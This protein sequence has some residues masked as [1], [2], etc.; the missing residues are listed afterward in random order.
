MLLLTQQLKSISSLSSLLHWKLIIQEPD[1][2]TSQ[3]MTKNH[4]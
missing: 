1:Q 4:L 3:S 2:S